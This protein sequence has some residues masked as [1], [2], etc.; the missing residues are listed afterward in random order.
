VLISSSFYVSM[1]PNDWAATLTCCS[2]T[3]CVGKSQSSATQQVSQ[4]R[5]TIS[6][7][8]YQIVATE[9]RIDRYSLTRN[10]EGML[11]ND[12]SA[13]DE[14][15]I[16]SNSAR[17]SVCVKEIIIMNCESSNTNY[18]SMVTGSTFHR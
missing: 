8:S 2:K 14:P 10:D 13:G 3:S 1:I 9:T 16:H 6:K 15:G 18:S 12:G 17:H 11:A 4:F 7:S 5:C